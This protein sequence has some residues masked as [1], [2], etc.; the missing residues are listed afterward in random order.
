MQRWWHRGRRRQRGVNSFQLQGSS[1]SA[2]TDV[3]PHPT[4]TEPF[5]TT[6]AATET[7]P[8][9]CITTSAHGISEFLTDLSRFG[10]GLLFPPPPPQRTL[11]TGQHPAQSHTVCFSYAGFSQHP[12]DEGSGGGW[13]QRSRAPS[14]SA[15]R[16]PL[17]PQSVK[18]KHNVNTSSS[19]PME[20][21][22]AHRWPG[23][24]AN[25]YRAGQYESG[26]AHPALPAAGE[27]RA[28]RS[29]SPSV[30]TSVGMRPLF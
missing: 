11:Q 4:S 5:W 18:G 28:A 8:R 2:D 14:S 25:R 26:P 16:S 24:L 13:K 3:Q 30:R 21:A 1:S 7:A 19:P 27:G 29:C 9:N 22:W 15:A 17:R 10:S 23:A 6:L 20:R 12:L